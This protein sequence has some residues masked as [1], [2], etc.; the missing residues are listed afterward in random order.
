MLDDAAG[1][2]SVRWARR[3]IAERLGGAR[4][5]GDVAPGPAVFDQPRGVF[6]TLRRHPDGLLR[7]C[8]GYPM[9]FLPLRQAL[10][11]AA[12]SAAFDDPRFPP[13]AAAELGHLIVEVSVLTVP[14]PVD[15]VGAEAIA[16]SV[17]VGRDGLIVEAGGRSGLLLPQVAPEQG[18]SAEEFLDGTCEKADL[19]RGAWRDPRIRIRRFEAEVFAETEPGGRVRRVSAAPSRPTARRAPRT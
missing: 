13:V 7:G 12:L 14:V 16:R 17:R 11:Q 2:A 5:D 9:P 18:W 4:S 3:S 8:I 19:P 6:V 10:A 15:A 1:E